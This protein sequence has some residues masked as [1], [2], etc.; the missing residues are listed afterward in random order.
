MGGEE[1]VTKTLDILYAEFKRCM[2]LCGCKS[3][4]DITPAKLGVVSKD[5]PLAKL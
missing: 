2:Q 5:G 3:I 4:C 1:G